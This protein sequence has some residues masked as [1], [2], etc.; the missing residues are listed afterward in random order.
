MAYK[1]EL[2]DLVRKL[3]GK[4]KT[5]SEIFHTTGIGITKSTISLWCRGVRLPPWYEKKVG[6]INKINLAHAHTCARESQLRSHSALLEGLRRQN[7]HLGEFC[8]NRNVLKLMLAM[9][10]LGEGAKWK[11]H[12]GLMLGSSDLRIILLY[13]NLLRLCYGIEIKDL[14]CRIC[15]RADQD[16]QKLERYWSSITKIPHENFYKTK[17]DHRTIGVPTRHKDYM[18]VCV[19]TCRGTAIQLELDIIAQLTLESL[20]R[21]L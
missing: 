10:Y 16:I 1:K 3:R 11:S 12:R 7:I 14:K 15:Y 4:G 5:Y 8:G 21:G 13:I 9:L 20:Q 18:G 19:I 2:R 6:K 17:P